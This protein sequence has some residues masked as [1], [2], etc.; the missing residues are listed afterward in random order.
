V[1]RWLPFALLLTGC[2]AREPQGASPAA[3]GDAVA[4]VPPTAIGGPEAPAR[5]G[6]ALA[7]VST[8]TTAVDPTAVE[9]EAKRLGLALVHVPGAREGH[10]F[11]LDDA[12][13]VL[14][15]PMPAPH[16]D[17][18][19]MPQNP[20]TATPDAL[21]ASRAHLIVAVLQMPGEP[22]SRDAALARVTAAVVAG[23]DAIGAMLGPGYVMYR[24]DFFRKVV[25]ET[26]AGELPIDVCIDYTLAGEPGDRAS[27]LT[28][29]LA[30][31]GRE[32]FYV[33][34]PRA[35]VDETVA[36]GRMM[37]RWMI[38]DPAKVLPTGDTVGRTEDEKIR[39]QRVADPRG[40]PSEVIRLDL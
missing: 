28:Y 8:R 34:G 10:E 23:S 32:E 15:A 13:T 26:P 31:Y 17:A 22:V 3:P 19:K 16:P 25:R 29:G 36:F 4:P 1:T 21:A 12:V 30:R 35:T 27:M 14:I 7:F 39:I 6:P 33:T 5:H 2:G 11:R 18:P 37:A 20:Y 24:A 38:L 40:S 9:A